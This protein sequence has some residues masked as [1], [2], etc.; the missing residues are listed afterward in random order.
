MSYA[1]DYGY[2]YYEPEHFYDYDEHPATK[3][4]GKWNGTPYFKMELS[5]LI[6]CKN[7]LERKGFDVPYEMEREIYYKTKGTL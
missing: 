6:N 7:L 5:H 1:D 2:D 3:V 4:K